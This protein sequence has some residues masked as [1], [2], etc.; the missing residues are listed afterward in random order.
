MYCKMFNKEKFTFLVIDKGSCDI[1]IFETS[2]EFLSKGKQKFN[3]AVSNYKYFFEQNNDL[4]QYV[5]R[6]L[7]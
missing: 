5:L 2:K 6:G 1:G 7:L 4:D 3:Q